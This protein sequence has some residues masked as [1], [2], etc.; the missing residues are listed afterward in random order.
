MEPGMHRRALLLAS[1]LWD[2]WPEGAFLPECDW[3]RIRWCCGLNQ[4]DYGHEVATTFG[5]VVDGDTKQ[6]ILTEDT[7]ALQMFRAALIDYLTAGVQP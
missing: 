7:A 1:D 3:E 4:P 6:V 5:F 2:G